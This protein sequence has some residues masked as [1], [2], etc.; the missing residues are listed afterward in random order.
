MMKE[1]DDLLKSKNAKIAE[2]IIP[3]Q[4][5]NMTE[6]SGNLCFLKG[7]GWRRD[8]ERGISQFLQIQRKIKLATFHSW[9][10]RPLFNRV[11][12][13]YCIYKEIS[14]YI[15]AQAKLQERAQRWVL[16][17]LVE[18][19]VVSELASWTD[20]L[21][22]VNKDSRRGK[23]VLSL[24]SLTAIIVKK[25]EQTWKHLQ[26]RCKTKLEHIY[27]DV[28]PRSFVR[29]GSHESCGL[30]FLTDSFEFIPNK[31]QLFL[32]KLTKDESWTLCSIFSQKILEPA[33]HVS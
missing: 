32:A 8:K 10:F 11:K 30:R 31:I 23:L 25:C 28:L 29:I 20:W 1:R 5:A 14:N 13:R 19:F 2:K 26:P 21:C 9:N 3:G 33:A 24:V 6:S 27:F 12:R 22:C 18:L 7:I 15:R 4:V 17:F 16:F